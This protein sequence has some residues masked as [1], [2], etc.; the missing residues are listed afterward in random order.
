MCT[1]AYGDGNLR[2]HTNTGGSD[3]TLYVKCSVRALRSI[4][5][6]VTSEHSGGDGHGHSHAWTCM[7]NPQDTLHLN[8]VPTLICVH[9]PLCAPIKQISPNGSVFRISM[10]LLTSDCIGN[11]TFWR[12]NGVFHHKVLP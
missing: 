12:A 8:V 10:S 1:S 3:G 11:Q 7:V 2:L 5:S 4:Q 9:I 6:W